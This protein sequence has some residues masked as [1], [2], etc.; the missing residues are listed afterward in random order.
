MGLPYG[1][2]SFKILLI[3]Y[4]RS[5]A[6]SFNNIP[7]I[8]LSTCYV[9]GTRTKYLWMKIQFLPSVGEEN[10]QTKQVTSQGRRWIMTTML[11]DDIHV[12]AYWQPKLYVSKIP[13]DTPL[14][15]GTC[16]VLHLHEWHLHPSRGSGQGAGNHH[17]PGSFS[18]CTP[19]NYK[20]ML[21]VPSSKYI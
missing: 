8:I 6:S 18:H 19:P 9:S 20:Q 2:K 12:G 13:P 17:L 10:M 14:P 3:K 16:S 21:L 11:S 15:T 5:R 1:A 7:Y 4:S